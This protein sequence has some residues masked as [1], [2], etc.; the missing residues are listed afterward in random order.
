MKIVDGQGAT[1][2]EISEQI[3][4]RTNNQA[5]YMAL[6]AA[7]QALATLKPAAALIRTDSEV[8]YH[9]MTGSYRVKNYGLALLKTRAE[10]LL[11]GL[12]DVEF[13]LIRRED[14][15]AADRLANQAFRKPTAKTHP[16]EPETLFSPG[17]ET[18][19][20]GF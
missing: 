8:L 4:W 16:L 14:N 3:G 6:L 10:K 17:N 9:Q 11:A 1:V 19:D 2:A 5:E 12:K 7:L 18:G 20:F 15:R 13:Q